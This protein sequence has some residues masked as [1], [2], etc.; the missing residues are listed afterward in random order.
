MIEVEPEENIA[1]G[2]FT[3]GFAR[4]AEVRR[5][6]PAAG[7][8]AAAGSIIAAAAG[9]PL[10]LAVRHGARRASAG[11]RA[12]RRASRTRSW[13]TWARPPG[14]RR[15]GPPTW[16][17][18]AR[19]GPAPRPRRKRSASPEQAA[20]GERP[21]ETAAQGRPGSPKAAARG[22]RTRGA[23]RG[24]RRP[25]TRT[26][27][28]S[29]HPVDR[30]GQAAN[31]AQQLRQRG[32]VQPRQDRV[33][34]REQPGNQL[35][36]VGELG[37][38]PL[39]LDVPEPTRVTGQRGRRDQPRR[40]PAGY[41]GS[42]SKSPPRARSPRSGSPRAATPVAASGPP[43]RRRRRGNTHHRTR[44]RTRRSRAPSRP[45]VIVVSRK[46]VGSNLRSNHTNGV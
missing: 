28:R 27:S 32:R 18:T 16:P 31:R 37:V 29:A 26:G 24:C 15:R 21:A 34:L 3:W 5:V 19:R 41:P 4:W 6:D 43:R 35:E 39:A 7:D 2:R 40:R 23:G 8:G 20:L 1:A 45:I 12:A 44:P 42:C 30:V 22:A 46:S 11:Q 17:P 33:D 25:R 36:P 13:W 9:R 38:R 14:R 10:V